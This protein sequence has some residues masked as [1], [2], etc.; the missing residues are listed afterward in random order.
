MSRSIKQLDL[1]LQ[2]TAIGAAVLY[3][4]WPLGDVLNPAANRG[5]ASNLGAVGQPYNWLFAGLDILS[6]SVIIIIALLLYGRSPR[7]HR[8]LLDWSIIGYGLFGGLTALAALLPIDC[9]DTV[10]RCSSLASHPLIIVH[11]LASIGSI[12]GLTI[13]IAGLWF[14]LAYQRRVG[15]ALRWLLFSIAIGWLGFAVATAIFILTN[16]SSALS[17]HLFI[18]LCSVWIGLLPYLVYRVTSVR[19]KVAVG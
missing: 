8:W 9:L 16:R 6:G 17:Q 13:S 14:L 10:Q 7:P 5:L 12:G 1:K 4:S 15:R 2:T 19:H 11:G 3:C 18:I